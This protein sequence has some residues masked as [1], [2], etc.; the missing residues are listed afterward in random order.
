MP[1]VDDLILDISDIHGTHTDTIKSQAV[2]NRLIAKKMRESRAVTM[3][4]E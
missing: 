2:R 1:K 3:K 4:T